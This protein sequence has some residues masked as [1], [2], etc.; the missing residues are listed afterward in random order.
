MRAHQLSFRQVRVIEVRQGDG[1]L[2][3]QMMVDFFIV[4]PTPLPYRVQRV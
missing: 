3:A 1:V 2:I 4:L